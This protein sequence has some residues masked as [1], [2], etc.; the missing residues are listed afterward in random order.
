MLQNRLQLV[1]FDR[2]R[3]HV[4]NIMHHHGAQLQIVV[5]FHA[6]LCDGFCDTL[7]VSAFELTSQ[8]VAKPS[9][10]AI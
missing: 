2:L 5:R 10:H 6:L 7:A 9:R 4:Q 3:H 8:K 1:L